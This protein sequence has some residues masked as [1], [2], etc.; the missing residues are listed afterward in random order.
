MYA[1]NIPELIKVVH[2]VAIDMNSPV[3]IH[4]GSGGGKSQGIDEA[5]R[6]YP[7]CPVWVA[8]VRAG[9]NDTVDIRGLPNIA[10]GMTRWNMASML[11]FIGNPLFDHCSE[12]VILLKLDEIDHAMS[13][14]AGMLYQIVMEREVSGNKLRDNVRIVAA[15]NR[16]KD[17][18]VSGGRFP[19]PLNRRFTHFELVS[20]LDAFA[21]YIATNCERPNYKGLIM[22]RENAS[23]L[24]AFLS[25]QKSYLD[26][27][28]PEKPEISVGCSR[29]WEDAGCYLNIKTESVRAGAIAGAVGDGRGADFLNFIQLKDKITPIKRIIADPLGVPLPDEASM[30]YA[31]TVAVSGSMNMK[32][33]KPLY[34]F[35]TRMSPEFVVLAWQLA[36]KRDPE[37]YDTNEFLDFTKTYKAVFSR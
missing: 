5:A 30:Q 19:E 7:K 32:T 34:Q 24:I 21:N 2:E 9:Q 26:S 33:A 12:G 11:P 25:W 15:R 4:G 37:L 29:T 17:K 6:T 14:V 16:A 27:Y 28:D 10:D 13:G 3:L 36:L 31:T 23:N 35:I 20:D 8:D 18:G 22:G 1:I